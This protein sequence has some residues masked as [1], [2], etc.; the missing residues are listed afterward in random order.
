MLQPLHLGRRWPL[1]AHPS[2]GLQ[3]DRRGPGLP[4]SC[5]QLLP[6][7]TRR[8]FP[9]TLGFFS[10]FLPLDQSELF[11]RPWPCAVEVVSSS[12]P[13]SKLLCGTTEKVLSETNKRTKR[14]EDSQVW[15][16][17]HPCMNLQTSAHGFPFSTGDPLILPSQSHLWKLPLKRRCPASMKAWL[18]LPS[19]NALLYKAT[20]FRK[21]FPK[22]VGPTLKKPWSKGELACFFCLFPSVQIRALCYTQLKGELSKHSCS[23][24]PWNTSPPDYGESSNLSQLTGHVSFIWLQ[25]KKT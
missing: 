22:T 20:S 9:S 14:N 5:A 23:P 11:P 24:H 7:I 3:T 17:N 8:Y 2:G 12:Y 25:V 18:S 4:V 1:V 13:E 15:S 16:N 21:V 10:V 19:R 6:Q